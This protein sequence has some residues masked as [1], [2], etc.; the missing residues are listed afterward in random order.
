MSQF[1]DTHSF[2]EARHL[3][4]AELFERNASLTPAVLNMAEG[5]LRVCEDKGI[6][7]ENLV[8]ETRIVSG[9]RIVIDFKSKAQ[10]LATRKKAS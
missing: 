5:I 1:K 6:S 8:V 9:Q 3:K 4:V 10:A 7:P 2:F